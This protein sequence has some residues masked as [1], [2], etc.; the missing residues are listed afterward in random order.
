MSMMK[1]PDAKP[2]PA[3][4]PPQ[5]QSRPKPDLKPDPKKPIF[6]DWAMI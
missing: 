4:T 3:P 2:K 1:P 6:T 5:Q